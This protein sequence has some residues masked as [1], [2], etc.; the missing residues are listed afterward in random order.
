MLEHFLR[1]GIL[2]LSILLL[3]SSFFLPS[4]FLFWLLLVMSV[5]VQGV[6]I[7]DTHIC[8]REGGFSL[9]PFS[10]AKQSRA[11]DICIWETRH[12]LTER[13]DLSGMF[14]LQGSVISSRHH[15]CVAYVC[16]GGTAGWR[17][18]VVGVVDLNVSLS[19]CTI[20]M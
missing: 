14:S 5:G 2:L 18:F 19:L 3:R 10:R 7:H 1:C 12:P 20:Q 17:S 16:R 13:H 9:V 11:K 6:L 15:I 4:F 8:L